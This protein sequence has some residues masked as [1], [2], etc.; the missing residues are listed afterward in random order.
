MCVSFTVAAGC[1]AALG[2]Y[3]KKS[4]Q[5]VLARYIHIVLFSTE[6]LFLVACLIL[7]I[8]LNRQIESAADADAWEAR[9]I[10]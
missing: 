4:G 1:N 5:A 7:G 6:V 3:C 2:I 8:L 10:F 9:I